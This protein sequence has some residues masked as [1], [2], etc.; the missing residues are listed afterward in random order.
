VDQKST[1]GSYVNGKRATTPVVIAPRDEIRLGEFTLGVSM[2][3]MPAPLPPPPNLAEKRRVNAWQALR[4]TMLEVL[5]ALEKAGHIPADV[6]TE[7]LVNNALAVC[8]DT[9]RILNCDSACAADDSQ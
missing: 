6:S 9:W 1:N 5:E 7:R 8:Q 4:R 2:E 3:E